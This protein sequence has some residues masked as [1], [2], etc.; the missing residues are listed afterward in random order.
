MN[1]NILKIKKWYQYRNLRE[2]LMLLGLSWILIFTTCHLFFFTPLNNRK[3]ELKQN[4]IESKYVI[5]EW[6]LK[7]NALKRISGTPLYKKWISQQETSLNIQGEY[8]SLM[9]DFSLTRWQTFFKSLL[10][11]QGQ[12]QLTQIKNS[13]ESVY[14][15]VTFAPSQP[16]KL[17]QQT[18]QL[19]FY[20]NYI[21]TISYLKKIEELLPN[22]YWNEFHYDVVRYPIAKAELEFLIFYDKNQ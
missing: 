8:G 14:T 4:I 2:R 20:S 17:Y 10:K 5:K 11:S 18:I 19:E 13:P 16:K 3:H 15:P 1:R 22:I 12:V 21:N 6:E 7:I 9:K